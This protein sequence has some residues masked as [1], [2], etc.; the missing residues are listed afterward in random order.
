MRKI[1]LCIALTAILSGNAPAENDF[2]ALLGELTFGGPAESAQTL[3]LENIAANN[4]A[5]APN[6]QVS[7]Q[8]PIADPAPIADPQPVVTEA[9]VMP[10]VDQATDAAPVEQ[11]AAAEPIPAPVVSPMP[12]PACEGGHCGTGECHSCNSCSSRQCCNNR[13]SLCNTSDC[14]LFNF[15]KMACACV[16]HTPPNLP[17]SSFYQYFKSNA[18]NCRVWDGYQNRCI[19]SSKHSRGQCDCFHHKPKKSCLSGLSCNMRGICSTNSCSSGSCESSS[20]ESGGCH[21][22]PSCWQGCAGEATCA[23]PAECDSACCDACDG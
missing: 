20:C 15:D 6:A 11:E 16:P 19:Y 10:E 23:A 18:C 1:A 14:K 13:Q 4:L 2:D 21:D 8:E 5:P 22:L 12:A 7:A 17:T 3:T 9:I